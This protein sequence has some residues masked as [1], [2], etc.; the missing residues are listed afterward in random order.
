MAIS[1][2]DRQP[3]SDFK[4]YKTY[5]ENFFN[6]IKNSKMQYMSIRVYYETNVEVK[7]YLTLLFQ[8]NLIPVIN[9]PKEYHPTIRQ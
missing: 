1:A 4:Q 2:Q 8:K 9:K 5:L 6:K 7:N 3:A